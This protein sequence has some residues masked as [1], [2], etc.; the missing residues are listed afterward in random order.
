MESG[1]DSGG[2]VF[3]SEQTSRGLNH[4]YKQEEEYSFVAQE[5]TKPEIP[6]GKQFLGSSQIFPDVFYLQNDLNQ[7]ML[8]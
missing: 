6:P 8:S 2:C 4:A 3:S 1:N 7:G 5:G